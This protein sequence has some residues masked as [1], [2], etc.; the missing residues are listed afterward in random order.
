MSAAGEAKASQ[1]TQG[2]TP[3]DCGEADTQ[4]MRT[5]ARLE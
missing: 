1:G 3:R 5:G 4:S 2:P